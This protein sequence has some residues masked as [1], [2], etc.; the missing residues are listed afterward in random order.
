MGGL[1]FLLLEI[2]D[3]HQLNNNERITS[4]YS[5]ILSNT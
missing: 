1:F 5:I 3:L 4:I 2:N